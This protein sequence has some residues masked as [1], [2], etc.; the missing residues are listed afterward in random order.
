MK[1]LKK[2][3]GNIL[4]SAFTTLISILAFFII[5]MVF[6]SYLNDS[7]VPYT[8]KMLSREYILRM[9]SKG[10]LDATSESELRDELEDLGIYD[11]NFGSTTKIKGDYGSE[12]VLEIYGKYDLKEYSVLST[13]DLSESTKVLNIHEKQTSTGKH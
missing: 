13:F 5:I 8:V 9:E 3:K 1:K 11:I 2:V 12:V 4:G 6:I 10:Y 7:N